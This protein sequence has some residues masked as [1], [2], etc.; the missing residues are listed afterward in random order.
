MRDLPA[1][2]GGWCCGG[3]VL[4]GYQDAAHEHGTRVRDARE[5]GPT[6]RSSR[7]AGAGTLDLKCAWN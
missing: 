1:P 7:Q 2:P 6:Q 3:G 4:T 5:R